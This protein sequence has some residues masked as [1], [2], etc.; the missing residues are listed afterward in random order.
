MCCLRIKN[1][2]DILD[3]QST[4]MKWVSI[5]DIGSL[6]LYYLVQKWE[7]KKWTFL[8]YSKDKCRGYQCT[9]SLIFPHPSLLRWYKDPFLVSYKSPVVITDSGHWPEI[10]NSF[11]DIGIDWRRHHWGFSQGTVKKGWLKESVPS[12]LIGH[13]VYT[14]RRTKTYQTIDSHK[15]CKNLS[16]FFSFLF[17]ITTVYF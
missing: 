17:I 5:H 12:R 4:P 9:V 6:P 10:G 7:I 11:P 8:M 3:V 14:G 15:K 16:T 13:P 2:F 1:K